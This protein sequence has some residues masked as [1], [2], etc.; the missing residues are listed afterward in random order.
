MDSA[1]SSLSFSGLVSSKRRLH[2]PLVIL[3]Q[4]EIQADRLGM[5]DMQIA[6]RLGREARDDAL[7]LAAGQI[8]FDDVADEIGNGSR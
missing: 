6:V 1:Y 7:V 3:R 4:A 2:L 8:G 5:A